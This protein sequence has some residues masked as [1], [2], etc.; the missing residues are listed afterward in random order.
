MVT[1][2]NAN[3]VPS[4]ENLTE[5]LQEAFTCPW[6]DFTPTTTEVEPGGLSVSSPRIPSIRQV[7]NV[8]K[9]LN[10][11]KVTGANNILAWVFK[12]F[13][14]QLAIVPHDII[15]TSIVQNK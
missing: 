3:Q 5:K 13:A 7:K 4:S 14:E 8:L 6:H 11:R 12:R 15:T 2:G 1:G 9:Q 10:A